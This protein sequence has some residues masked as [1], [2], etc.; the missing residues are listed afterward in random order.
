MKTSSWLLYLFSA[1]IIVLSTATLRAQLIDVHFINDSYGLGSAGGPSVGP[2]MSGAAL[3]GAAGDTWNNISVTNGTGLSLTNAD[4]SPSPVTITF[5]ADGGYDVRAFGGS[6]P[7]TNT[8]YNALME[9]YLFT[10]G[11][12]QTITLSNLTPNSPYN[13]VLYSGEDHPASNR[14]TFFTVNSNAQVSTWNGTSS[15]FV[16]GI[17]YVQFPA[18]SDASGNLVITWAGSG[19]LEGD[20]NGFQLQPLATQW[21]IVWSDEFNGTSINTNIWT[22]DTGDGGWGNNELETYTSDPQNSYVSNGLLHIV[23]QQTGGGT[24]YTSA[25]MKTDGLY[26][27]PVY[28]RFQWRAALPSGTGMWPALWMLGSD[29]DYIGWPTCGEIDVVENDG[30]TPTWVQG[31]LH[32]N[33]GG[34]TAIYDLPGGESTTNFHIYE[35]DWTPT[36]IQWLVDGQ[37]YE[38]QSI[39]APFNAPFFFLMN[40]AVGGNYVNNPTTDQINAGTVFPQQMLVDYVRV[41]ELTEPL[42]IT[43]APASFGYALTWPTNIVCHLQVQTNSLTGKWT[44]LPAATSPYFVIPGP[45]QSVFYRL[46]SP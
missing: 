37:L 22:Y 18:A 33:S 27:T 16:D 23:V 4:G 26:D 2:A 10:K 41:L 15:N 11:V 6:T 19:S 24:G 8:P 35:M 44:D 30:A 28:G 45:T 42:A 17:D 46:E 39:G 13:L 20:I 34:P 40:V 7:F 12:P 14:M 43:V 31:S 25:R 3:L 36:N 5:A 32:S 21:N 29:F 38:T 9:C 1:A